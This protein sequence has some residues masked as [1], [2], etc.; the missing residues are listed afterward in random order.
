M[1]P[2][3]AC[4]YAGE[5]DSSRARVAAHAVHGKTS[6]EEQDPSTEASAGEGGGGKKDDHDG[7]PETRTNEAREAREPTRGERGG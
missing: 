6:L 5:G 2:S 3:P 7:G 4:F 1:G